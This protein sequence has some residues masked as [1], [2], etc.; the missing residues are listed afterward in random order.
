MKRQV[1]YVRQRPKRLPGAPRTLPF[2]PGERRV[3]QVMS[4]GIGT[5]AAIAAELG[6]KEGTVKHRMADIRERLGLRQDAGLGW[7]YRLMWQLGRGDLS[8]DDPAGSGRQ[9]GLPP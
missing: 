8:M 9:S 2:S 4:R 7:K 6:L 3:L 5:N 1:P